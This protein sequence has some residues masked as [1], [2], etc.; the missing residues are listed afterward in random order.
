[1]LWN[2]EIN[3]IYRNLL[4]IEINEY[5]IYFSSFLLLRVSALHV[6]LQTQDQYGICIA[7]IQQELQEYW[8]LLE[9]LHTKVTLQPEKG[10]EDPH[11]VL[12]D[13]EVRYLKNVGL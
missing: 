5:F 3:V 2:I 10:P 9:D 7:N 13:T 4:Q 8:E 6:L 11:T 12:V 1:M